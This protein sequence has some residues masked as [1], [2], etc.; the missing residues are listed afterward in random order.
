M[1]T[2]Q[3]SRNQLAVGVIAVFIL[4]LVGGLAWSFGRQILLLR[5]MK[6]EEAR[7]EQMT[8]TEQARQE[9]LLAQLDY[10]Q[11]EEYMEHWAREEFRMAKPGE[12]VVITDLDAGEGSESPDVQ[13]DNS[14]E[15][16]SFWVT[17]WKKA[18]GL[19][20]P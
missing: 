6:A 11:T 15:S 12:V 20:T 13:S 2:S 19:L 17:W 7:L 18:R 5:K 9:D 10:V 8:A 3:S 4:A 16:E 1:A 14:S